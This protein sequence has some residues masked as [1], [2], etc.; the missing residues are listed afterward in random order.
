M[1]EK[2]EVANKM[3]LKAFLSSEMNEIIKIFVIQS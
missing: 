3:G 2:F 1:F